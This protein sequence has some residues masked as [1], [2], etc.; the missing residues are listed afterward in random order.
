ML[1]L[2]RRGDN[3]LRAKAIRDLLRANELDPVGIRVTSA[4]ITGQL[5]LM[6]VQASTSLELDECVFDEPLLLR[7]TELYSLTLDGSTMPELDAE[8]LRTRYFGMT[9]ARCTGLVDLDNARIDG[10]LL[11]SGSSMWSFSGVGMQVSRNVKADGLYVCA[12]HDGAALDLGGCEIGDLDLTG[13]VVVNDSGAAVTAVNARIGGTITLDHALLKA[14]GEGM[15]LELVDAAV[16]GVIA[17]WVVLRSDKGNA[18]SFDGTHFRSLVTLAD[19]FDLRS[20][21]AEAA[22][23]VV[24][25]WFGSDLVMGGSV[26]A[27]EGVAL[28]MHKTKIE[29]GLALV[30]IAFESDTAASAVQIADTFVAGDLDFRPDKLINHGAG[31]E[32]DLSGTDVGDSLV[33]NVP[34]LIKAE[35]FLVAVN[36]LTYPEPPD[37]TDAWLKMLRHHTFRYHP[38]PYQQLAGVHRA[39]GHEHT[40]RKILIAQQDDLH[41]FGDP[42][43]LLWHRF[44]GVTLGYGYRPSRAVAGLLVTFLLSICLVWTAGQFGGLTPAKDRPADACSPVNRISLAADLAIPLVKFGGTPRCELANGPA[45]QWATGAGWVVQILGWSFATLSVAGF[46]GLVRKS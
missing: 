38:Q 22:I 46:T 24:G 17:R 21:A 6:N 34:E 40:A 20:G 31:H 23:R 42:G 9:D 15:A 35:F 1:D 39:V 36:G 44:L 33:L 32:L 10:P 2:S 16:D 19:G 12:D 13:A 7:D 11:L 43:N 29:A 5:D 37:D 45:G 8:G 25:T 3:R 4:R 14:N 27:R 28:L 18:I 30:E 26:R 41:D